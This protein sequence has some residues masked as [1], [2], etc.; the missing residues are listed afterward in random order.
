M[1]KSEG[2]GVDHEKKSA[3]VRVYHEKNTDIP[4]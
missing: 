1:R 3:G 2:V 4:Y